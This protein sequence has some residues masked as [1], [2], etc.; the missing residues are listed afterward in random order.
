M[1]DIERQAFLPL[2]S[3]QPELKPLPNRPRLVRRQ[4]SLIIFLVVSIFLAIP[5]LRQIR[6]GVCGRPSFLV[7]VGFCDTPPDADWDIFYHLGGNGP[8]IPKID[9]VEYSNAKLPKECAVDQVHMVRWI[10]SEFCFF[11]FYAYT[12][13]SLV[14]PNGIPRG[15]P[16]FV[17]LI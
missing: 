14:T 12:N 3:S 2:P 4:L 10:G 17:S 16:D 8:W 7:G 5:L 9:G 13:S 11:S 6:D 15:I 1:S